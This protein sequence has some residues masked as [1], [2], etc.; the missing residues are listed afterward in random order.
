MIDPGAYASVSV[1][2]PL[3]AH[4]SHLTEDTRS[5]GVIDPR[6]SARPG[7]TSMTDEALALSMIILFGITH[8]AGM[9]SRAFQVELGREHPNRN[10]DRR[11]S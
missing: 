11:E 6:A 5:G 8:V 3:A 7:Y 2:T 1:K 9:I 10:A 4:N